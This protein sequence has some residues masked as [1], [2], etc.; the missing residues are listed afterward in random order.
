L[1]NPTHTKE[2]ESADAASTL[3]VVLAR[4]GDAAAVEEQVRIASRGDPSSHFHHAAYNIATAWALLG[5]KTEALSWLRKTAAEGM[6]C[7]P[8]FERDPFLDRVRSDPDFQAFLATQ[9]VLWEGLRA[10]L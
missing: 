7:Y 4:D 8:L 10:A 2:D 9:R 3:A 1:N 6:P 5:R